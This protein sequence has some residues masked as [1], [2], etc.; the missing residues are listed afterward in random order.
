MLVFE[1]VKFLR[2]IFSVEKLF[3]IRVIFIGFLGDFGSIFYWCFGGIKFFLGVF[4]CI[5]LSGNSDSDYGW[6]ISVQSYRMQIG[7]FSCNIK[8]KSHSKSIHNTFDIIISCFLNDSVI[9]FYILISHI[10][11]KILGT[12][13]HTDF[14]AISQLTFHLVY[15]YFTDFLVASLVSCPLVLTLLLSAHGLAPFCRSST[16]IWVCFC[17]CLYQ[18][19]LLGIFLSLCYFKCADLL[20]IHGDVHLNPAP[21]PK[22]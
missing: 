12:S 1:H 7:L 18:R 8:I 20:Y 17:L 6:F 21:P 13:A 16:N 3:Y 11:S 2:F 19:G 10:F 22:P 14:T 4:F 9:I 15:P 5:S